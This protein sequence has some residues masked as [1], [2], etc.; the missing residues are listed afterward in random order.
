[1]LQ[2]NYDIRAIQELLGHGDLKSTMIYTPTVQSV[3][4]KQDKSP[5]DF[6]SG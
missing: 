4:I 5:L 3:T 2:A 6:G 1:L